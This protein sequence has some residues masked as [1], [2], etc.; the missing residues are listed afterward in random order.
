MALETTAAHDG[1]AA[2]RLTVVVSEALRTRAWAILPAI[3]AFVAVAALS[4]VFR[5]SDRIVLKPLID[6][7][8][9][10]LSV[11]ENIADGEGVTID[12]HN[13]TNGFQP[14]FTFV[15]APAFVVTDSKA[16]ALRLVTLLEWALFLG[17]GLL[18]G[19]IAREAWPAKDV[20]D[21]RLVFWIAAVS[22]VTATFS[23][24]TH[25]NGLETGALL[26]MYAL[27]W[28]VYQRLGLATLSRCAAFGAVLGLLVLT[29]VDAAIFV[30]AI[31]AL[32]LFSQRRVTIAQRTL[33][34][35]VVS[36]VAMLVSSPWWIYNV[37]EFGALMPSS[38][39]AEQDISIL[40]TRIP[41]LLIALFRAGAPWIAVSSW[42]GSNV[43]HAARFATVVGV[44][45]LAWYGRK[46]MLDA[47]ESLHERPILRRHFEFGAALLITCG[48]FA[49][50]YLETSGAHWFY[51]RYLAPLSLVAAL[52]LAY[53]LWQAGGRW[54]AMP[55]VVLGGMAVLTLGLGVAPQFV[56]KPYAMYDQ[57]LLVQE[58]VPEGEVVAAGQTGGLGFFRE[59]VVNLDGKVNGE[60]IAYQRNMWEYLREQNIAWFVDEPFYF[61]YLGPDLETSGWTPVATRGTFTLFKYDGPTADP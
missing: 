43:V 17:T 41:E 16:A 4:I 47:A 42:D 33:R 11:S 58:H 45:A 46:P 14:L 52:V 22:Y 56:G 18:L 61:R 39:T 34:A 6:D 8:Y 38:G 49:L 27:A 30:V 28:L 51:D 5:P 44:I 32:Q 55:P 9:Y 23:F 2:L 59:N 53:G 7:A 48:I 40:P 31:A 29:R 13:L 1:R 36:T 20:A 19:L 35:G 21:Q 26:F 15:A 60:A 50:W 25:F 54:V 3:F 10:S 57:T 12:G 24:L 37:A